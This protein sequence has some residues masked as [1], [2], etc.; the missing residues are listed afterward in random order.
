L[1]AKEVV[2]EFP[3]Q[4]RMRVEDLGAS[5]LAN[6]LG[7]DKYPAVFVDEALVARPEDFYAWGGPADGKY[8]PFKEL[9]NKREFQR[10]L[11]KLIR[12]RLAGES[13][14]DRP[15][16]AVVS[17]EARLPDITLTDLDGKR[18]SLQR[19]DRPRV[20][21]VWA[22]W[23]VFCMETLEWTKG[24]DPALA[25]VVGVV[26]DSKE[27]DV[28]RVVERIQPQARI[29]VATRALREALDG[30]PAVPMLIVADAAGR[31]KRTF[32]G[33]TP[34]LHEDVE[35]ELRKLSTAGTRNSSR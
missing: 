27:E 3:Q 23:C 32:Y 30:P 10:D 8:L 6:R 2:N 18:V 22:T 35:K 19:S 9:E 7:I 28:R 15:A 12:L 14:P 1:L 11:R 17:R 21:E 20:I 31:V 4:V 16:S 13:I 25:E 5:P 33:A 24:L 29:V 26:V 34:T